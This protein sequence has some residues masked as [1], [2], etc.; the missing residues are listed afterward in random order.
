[1]STPVERVE[2]VGADRWRVLVRRS[3]AGKTGDGSVVVQGAHIDPRDPPHV[4][5]AAARAWLEVAASFANA[6]EADAAAA[7]ARSGLD[8]LGREYAPPM[9]KDD[10]SLRVAAAEHLIK[11]GRTADAAPM[12][13]NA[14][15][16]RIALYQQEHAED[17]AE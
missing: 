12:L 7:A 14:L 10:T 2:S 4:E 9:I 13:V 5:L 16:T 8:E 11:Q 17:L 3:H 1:M 15:E 6:G